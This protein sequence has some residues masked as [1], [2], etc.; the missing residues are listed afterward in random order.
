MNRSSLS[1]STSSL[2]IWWMLPGLGLIGLLTGA[3]IRSLAISG[4]ATGL[5]IL[6]RSARWRS[7]LAW[8]W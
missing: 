5:S 3:V 7:W 4:W 1:V 6:P 8:C 2:N